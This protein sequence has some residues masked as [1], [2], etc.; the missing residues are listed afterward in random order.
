MANIELAKAYVTI[1]PSLTGAQQTITEELTGVSSTA[2]AQAGSDAGEAFNVNFSSILKGVGGVVAGVTGALA[3]GVAAGTAALVDMTREGATYADTVLTMSTNTHIGTDELQAYMYAAELVDVSVDTMTSS[4]A[5]NVRSMSS[6]ADGT[7]AV[8]EA[9]AALGV[10]VTDSEGNLRDSQ[11]VYW[12]LIDALGQVESDTERDALSMQIFGRSAQDLN[13]LIAVGSEGM[14]EY[15]AQAEDAGAILSGDTLGAFG[16]FD[17]V[18]QQLDSGVGAAK[19]ALGTVLL[20]V[21]T[22]LGGEGVDL[23]GQFTTGILEANGDIDMIAATIEGLIPQVVGIINQYLPTVIELGG[24]II[25]SLAQAILSNLGS[26]LSTA[27]SVLMTLGEGIIAVLPTLA[28]IAT[29]LIVNLA[30]FIIDNLGTVIE[31]ALF[32]VISV[33]EGISD[34]LPELIPA[35]VAAIY[36]IVETLT[37]PDSVTALLGAALDICIALGEGLIASIPV[38][39]ENI[40]IIIENIMA[41]FMALGDELQTSASTWAYDMMQSFISGI[42]NMIGNVA[43]AASSIASTIQSYIGFSEPEKGPLS[44]FH[45]YAPDMID[46]FTEG[47]EESTPELEATLATSLALPITAAPAALESGYLDET[48]GA[49][50]GDLVIPVYIGQ[51][52]LD[53]IMIRSSQIAQY[54]RGS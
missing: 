14:A 5:R 54:R 24:S 42:Q 25:S 34:A 51:E 45:T 36:Q 46:L 50:N 49:E 2:G 47:L 11:E 43:S 32:I 4:M 27:G 21:L 13:S 6:A 39:V 33:A 9:Y 20:P 41:S 16:E 22:D 30:N 53:T 28:P 29:E 12:E 48:A 8:A 40:P 44:N 1:V 38:I 17:D 52:K 23:L 18:M 26:I 7:G 35:A 31:S 19:N 37:Q 3:A 10:A 15:A